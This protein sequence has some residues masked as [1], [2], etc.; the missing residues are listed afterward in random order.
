MDNETQSA[1]TDLE[2]RVEAMRRLGVSRWSDIELGPSPDTS[3]DEDATQRSMRL[4]RDAK[5]RKQ[6]LR[7]GATGGPRPVASRT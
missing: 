7:F 2:A 4:E 6:L 1:I 3:P 5:E